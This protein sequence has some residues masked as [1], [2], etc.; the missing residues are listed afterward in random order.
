MKEGDMIQL[1]F[2][3]EQDSYGL[4]LREIPSGHEDDQ[5]FEV[6]YNSNLCK[7]ETDG[8]DWWWE[9]DYDTPVNNILLIVQVK[10]LQKNNEKN[11]KI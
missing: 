4:V 8:I 6:L 1:S 9:E 5:A 2:N 7:L 10:D 11:N 3:A